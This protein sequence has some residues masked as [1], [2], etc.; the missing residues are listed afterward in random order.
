MPEETTFD[1]NGI[2]NSLS[3]INGMSDAMTQGM[4]STVGETRVLPNIG[5]KH[6]I[7]IAEAPFCSCIYS[8]LHPPKFEGLLSHHF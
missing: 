7:G 2:A 1:A 6:D 3:Y 5:T 8:D 4:Y